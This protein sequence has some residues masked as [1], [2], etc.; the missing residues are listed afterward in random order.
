MTTEKEILQSFF[1]NVDEDKRKFAFDTI[2]EY[3]F[4]RERIEELKALPY[5]Q[6][7]KKNPEMQ[8]LTPAA[9]LI[10]EYSQIIDAKRGTLLRIL[11][12][13]ETAA[14]DELLAKLAEFE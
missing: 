4:F 12:G 3:V 6:V 10:K 14:A 11:N 1:A 7:S 5:I 9:K 8:R 2:D 13:I